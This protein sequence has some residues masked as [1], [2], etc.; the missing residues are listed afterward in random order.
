MLSNKWLS[1]I[2]RF[3]FFSVCLINYLVYI[4]VIWGPKLTISPFLSIFVLFFFNF[5]FIMSTWSTLV[6]STSDPGQVPLY[7]GFYMGD[8]D[9]K[10]SR[11]CLMCNLFKPERCHHCSVCNR[12]VLNMDH[13]CPWINNCIGFYNKKY[14]FQM[15][16]YLNITLIFTLITNFSFEYQTF[17]L[18]LEIKI[19]ENKMLVAY[20]CFILAV[21]GGDI[22]ME[23][24]LIKF[25]KFHLDLILA[26]K[27]TI[28]NMEQN[29]RAKNPN[30]MNE[31]NKKQ[32]KKNYSLGTYENFLQV[33]GTSKLLWFF[34]LKY[35]YGKPK[36][37]GLDWGI[38]SDENLVDDEQ[39]NAEQLEMAQ[40]QAGQS[41][42]NI[43]DLGITALSKNQ[44][45]QSSLSSLYGKSGISS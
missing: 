34:P 11:Y 45:G 14:F 7:W 40:Q 31:G 2:F 8:S 19:M 21:Y 43:S 42:N 16:C 33:M 29:D 37:N 20:S 26:N 15:L 18:L 35:Y 3:V 12:C 5:S 41:D 27:T 38:Q 30:E 22:V 4:F 39:M 1:I 44:P 28:E 25:W 13:H 24:F 9:S 6:T 10:R 23:Y 32:E 17:K 36:G